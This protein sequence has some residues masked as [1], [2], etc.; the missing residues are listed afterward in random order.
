MLLLALTRP[1]RAVVQR[2]IRTLITT[3]TTTSTDSTSHAYL[4]PYLQSK[5]DAQPE[6]EDLEGVMCLVLNRPE[7]KNALSVRM[8]EE[9][10][11]GIAK[12]DSMPI[13]SARILL[14]HSSQPDLFCSGADLRERRTMSTSQVSSFLDSLRDMLRELEG[15]K[16]PSIAVIDGYA[17]GGGAELA[18]GC[19]LRVGGENTKIALPETKLGIIPGAGGT[20]RLTHLV[21]VSKAKELIYTGRHIDGVEAECIGL[22]NTYSPQPFQSA[23]SLSRQIISSAPLALA[24]AKTAITAATR[25][26]LEDGLDLERRVYNKLLDT[27]DRQE[28]LKAFKEKRKAVFKGR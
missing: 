13:S 18:L 21:G 26:P 23:L 24:S 16:I 22:I 7:T 17:L 28:G 10:R 20:Q 14:L 19:D 11:E 9:M 4:R 1:T 6:N 27:E 25:S 2:G 5:D 12:L 8:V 3:T 15:I